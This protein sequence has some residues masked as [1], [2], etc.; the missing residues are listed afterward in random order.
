MTKSLFSFFLI[1]FFTTKLFPQTPA[2]I[3]SLGM[4][5]FNN[6]D[7]GE[8]NYYF[9]KFFQE[10]NEIDEI[11]SIA[12]YYSGESLLSL[13]E[14][15]AASERFEFLANNFKWSSF[16]DISLYKLG[17]IYFDTKKFE[18][19]RQRLTVLINDYP[20]SQ[21][22]GPALYWIGESYV[23][24]GNMDEA[25]KFLEDAVTKR[26]AN[27]Y[28]DYSIYSL[29]NVYERKGNYSKAVSYYDQLLSFYKDSK[30]AAAS[31]FRI[32]YCYFKLS[33]YQSAVVELSNPVIS[34][35]DPSTHAEALYVLANSHYRLKE[36]NDSENIF[37][38]LILGYPTSHLLRSASYGLAWTHFQQ[39]RF[40]DAYKIFDELSELDDSIGVYSFYWKAESKRYAKQNS[41]ALKLFREFIKKYPNSSLVKNAK[42]QTASIYYSENNI[43]D[44]EKFLLESIDSEDPAVKSKAY[45][46]LGEL[47]LDRQNYSAAR[48]NF[49]VALAL[50]D[51]SSDFYTIALL[52]LGITSFK[53]SLFND[54]V[55]YLIDAE[56]NNSS[57]ESSKVNFY[58]AESY[59]AKGNYAEAIKRYNRVGSDDVNLNSL[60]LYGKA[61]S[62]F[63]MRDYENAVLNFS[64][65]IK[66][67][68]FDKRTTDARLRLA[69]SY[70]GNK[71][72][73][74]ASKIYKEI[75]L[76]D[77]GLTNDP[78][79]QYQY[80]QAL[81]KGGNSSEAISQFRLLQSTFPES[82]YA[83]KSLY[84]IGWIF[85]Q[86]SSFSEAINSYRSLLAAYPNSPLIPLA[87]YSIGDA[88]FNLSRYDSSIANYQMVINLFP[89][90]SYVFD[91]V[92][93][94][95]LCYL[96]QNQD[97]KAISV[98]DE[99]VRR[100]PG[101]SFS[102]ELFFKRGEIYYS[103]GN[104]EKA[105]LSYAEFTSKYPNSKLSGSAYYWIGKCAQNLNRPEEAIFNFNKVFEAYSNNH[106]AAAAVIEMGNIYNQLKQYDQAISI[107]EKG[108]EK[109]SNSPQTA[110][111]LFMKA[112]TYVNKNDLANAYDVFEEVIM[113]YGDT[114]FADRSKLEVGLI[115]Y[116]AKRYDNAVTYLRNVAE[117][118]KDEMG[119]KAQYYNGLSLFEQGKINEAI[120]AFVR[121]RT[122]FSFYEEWLSRSNLMLGDCYKKLNDKEKAKQFYREVISRHRG[123]E[124]G[125][126]AQKKLREIQ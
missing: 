8:A 22:F 9:E 55:K 110:E 26:R 77:K 87:Y 61:Y 96:A 65:F 39:K 99:F 118:R 51:K 44:S 126:I 64:D 80:A 23:E 108:S 93:G 41:E 49:K 35:L 67:Y 121:V 46:L 62:Y 86:R 18:L 59:F 123:D 48:E 56:N 109:L 105:K 53:L 52:G 45:I 12:K 20:S 107:Y 60:S 69:D 40:A 6:K 119:A 27:K 10:H 14:V 13:G 28:I 89:N 15:H 50:S 103:Q 25:V 21:Y 100:N 4:N 43:A 11:Y 117:T 37:R 32:G 76:T 3:F 78:Y 81:Y 95:V 72:Y 97:E 71:S 124:L 66:K 2:E 91:A 57:F 34:S 98:I 54:A 83:D 79:V 113:Y 19:S 104:Y 114:P 68:T 112:L 30:F 115:E 16:R 120:E 7:Y 33:D 17:L 90:S 5:A 92:N 125:K 63:N 36:F 29:A 88:F 106:L 84:I 101:L 42:Y 116:S 73:A 58:L 38:Q 74:S 82:E 70:Y 31:Q 47:N 102:D 111:I 122:I 94:I 1:L 75:Y 85:F 24:E